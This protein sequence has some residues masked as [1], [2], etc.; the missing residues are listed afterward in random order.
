MK[1]TAKQKATETTETEKTAEQKATETPKTAK[2]AEQKTT[3]TAK[4]A[5]QKATETPKTAKTAEQKATE[6]AET[7]KTAEQK[8]TETTETAKTAEQKTAETAKKATT[9]KAKT[10]KEPALKQSQN[11]KTEPVKASKAGATTSSA[12][13]AKKFRTHK[14]LKQR[15]GN[16]APTY[17][18]SALKKK[19]E[20]RV[21]V[22]YYVNSAGF[23]EKIQLNK[24]SG[25]SALDNSALRA[26]ARYR[27]H[28]G[29]EGWV[30]HPVEFLLEW[31][32]EIKETAP[33]GGF[34][35]RKGAS[36]K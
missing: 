14:Q 34:P 30:T 23:V 32:K 31:D 25:Y 36:V 28:P 2:T 29:Q 18:K 11:K 12:L 9:T 4:T 5:E 33:L 10:A 17:P 19:W 35:K 15:K 22:M 3:E 27:Y 24:S 20:G 26:L 1:K 16:K 8:A 13:S 6:T 21:E 7:A